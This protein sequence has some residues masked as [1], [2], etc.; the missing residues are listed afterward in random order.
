MDTDIKSLKKAAKQGISEELKNRV[1]NIVNEKEVD[2][3]DDYKIYWKNNPIERN[4]KG[5]NYLAPELEIIADDALD[6][7]TQENLF[8]FLSNWLNAY[9]SEELEHLINLIKL[10][11]NNQYIRAT[12]F[13]LYENNGILKR[14]GVEEIIP[15]LILT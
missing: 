2:L 3:R 9:I 15:G 11:N 12:A 13:R 5:K 14:K 4:R 6:Q 1:N 7:K 8:I 10:K